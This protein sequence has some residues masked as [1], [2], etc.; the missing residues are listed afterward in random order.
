[1]RIYYTRPCNFVYGNYAK[2]LLE[3]KKALP[4]AGNSNVAFEKVE[5]IKRKKKNIIKHML[6]EL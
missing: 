1:M 3:K 2:K 6:K 4:L 5:I